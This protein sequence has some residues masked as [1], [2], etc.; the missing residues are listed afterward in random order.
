MTM[1]IC[2]LIVG[3]L[4][5]NLILPCMSQEL[6]DGVNEARLEQ[7]LPALEI[8]QPLVTLAT[9]RSQDMA[10]RGYFS[11]ITLE[12]KTVFDMLDARQIPSPYA[13]EIL[14]RTGVGSAEGVISA[15]MESPCHRKVILNQHYSHIGIGEAMDSEGRQYIVIIF[16]GG[17]A[18]E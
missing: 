12:G 9:E 14:A 11:H 1:M 2:I 16:I 3:C 8:Y 5:A 10:T 18:T 17:G 13:G 6:L 15:F 4:W 7:D